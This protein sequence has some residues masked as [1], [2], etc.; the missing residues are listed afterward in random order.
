MDLRG[1]SDINLRRKALEKELKIKLSN[2]GSY[3]LDVKAASSK[4]CENMIGVVQIP[5]GVAGPLKIKSSL[6][7]REVYIPLA[8]TEGALVASVNRG[9]KAI[10]QSGGTNV[11]SKKVGITRAPVFEVENIS[12]SKEIIEWVKDN[13]NELRKITEGTSAH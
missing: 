12:Q 3:S 4:N 11:I 9:C 13:I 10:M 7:E 5:L 8:T 2:V 6:R 1:F